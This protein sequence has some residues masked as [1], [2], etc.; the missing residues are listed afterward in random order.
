[1]KGEALTV[2]QG[3]LN[4]QSKRKLA[5]FSK[6]KFGRNRRQKGERETRSVGSERIRVSHRRRSLSECKGRCFSTQ[7]TV[8][9]EEDLRPST[10][11]GVHYQQTTE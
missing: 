5:Q 3:E 10:E 11:R 9:G 7:T 1:M 2:T 6:G 8:L 4:V